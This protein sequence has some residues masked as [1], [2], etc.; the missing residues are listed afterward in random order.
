MEHVRTPK[1]QLHEIPIEFLASFS[2]APF[3][4]ITTDKMEIFDFPK[5][6]LATSFIRLLIHKAKNEN[7]NRKLIRNFCFLNPQ[8]KR[9]CKTM[10]ES[11]YVY[12]LFDTRIVAGTFV[13]GK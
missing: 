2:F 13:N 1:G 9:N 5:W 10:H 7:D 8:G 3:G 11:M 4:Y 12:I 6:S